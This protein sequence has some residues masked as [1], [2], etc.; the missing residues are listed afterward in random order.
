M[1]AGIAT[2]L[3]VKATAQQP[4]SA[5][6]QPG[7]A[8]AAASVRSPNEKLNMAIVGVAGRGGANLNGFSEEN[9]AVLCDVD[10]AHLDAAG[11][12]FPNAR[13]VADFRRVFDVPN[14]DAV[15]VST[16]DHT[17]AFPVVAALERGLPVYCEKPLAHSV[18]EVRQ[19]RNWASRANVKT[20]LGTHIHAGDNYRRA[21]EVVQSG[22]IGEVNRV[23]VWLEGGMRVF[24]EAPVEPVPASVDYDLWTGPAPLR[25]FSR[26]HFHFNWRYWWDFGNGALGD[27]GCHYM[28]LPF[29][30]LHLRAP[31]SVVARG[32]KGHNG[33]NECPLHLTVDY[34]FPAR[35]KHPPV[36][37][38]WYQGNRKP[39]DF[40]RYGDGKRSG[41]L[42][43]GTRGRLLADYGSRRIFWGEGVEPMT[44]PET[45]PASIG[46]HQEFVRAIRTRATTTCPFDYSGALTEAV[47]LGNVSYRLGG[48]ELEWDE[49][50]LRVTNN[51][52]AEQYL[53]RPYR[54]GWTLPEAT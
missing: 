21:V 35:A 40:A 53:R 44:P 12:R 5:A 33:L 36:H 54:A 52:D 37:L 50:E 9:I 22:V 27:F 46:H 2:P 16:P 19:I 13:K 47:L 31:L 42:F 4:G 23:H 39:D 49:A 45:I 26:A 30:A 7:T 51:A 29:W 17:H 28:D 41:V 8:P 15:V 25:P 1:A 3:A 20:Q 48:R 14:L 11:Q 24:P 43:E 6:Q 10:S 34:R 32:E 18:W 38:T